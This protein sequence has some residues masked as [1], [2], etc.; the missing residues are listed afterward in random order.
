M[1]EGLS[2]QPLFVTVNFVRMV[3]ASTTKRKKTGSNITLKYSTKLNSK[4]NRSTTAK[5]ENK[6]SIQGG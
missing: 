1:S 3:L 5:R 2:S 6:G 4:L